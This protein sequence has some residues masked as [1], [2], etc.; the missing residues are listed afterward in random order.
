MDTS[1]I[2]IAQAIAGLDCDEEIK[3]CLRKLFNE[4]LTPSSSSSVPQSFYVRQVE[5][6]AEDWTPREEDSK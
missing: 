5:A 3:D 2:A 6:Y 1:S 4:E